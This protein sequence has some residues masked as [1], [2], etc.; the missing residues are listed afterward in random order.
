MIV[1]RSPKGW[2]CPK[3]IDGKRA[4]D[5][6]RSH[7]VPMAEVR[8]NPGHIKVLEGW[9]KSYKPEELFDERG[10]FRHDLAELAPKGQRRMSANPHANGGLLLR[11]LQLPDFRDYA[12]EVDKPGAVRRRGD[13][14]HGQVPA[15]RHEVNLEQQ[16]LSPIQ[17]GREQFESLAG[18]ARRD[19][20]RLDS[21]A[22]SLTTTIWRPMAG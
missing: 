7:Q 16:K 13:A 19:E 22:F 12:V 9:M 11:D 20:P 17:P 8:D 14:R 5:Y 21:G 1:L 10:R 15:R 6:W 2:T 4:E 18:R 3:E